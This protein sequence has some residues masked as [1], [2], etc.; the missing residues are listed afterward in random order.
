[1]KKELLLILVPLI[2]IC[3]SSHAYTTGDAIERI[4]GMSVL[5]TESP[6]FLEDWAIKIFPKDTIVFQGRHP[7]HIAA[8]IEI[9]SRTADVNY[10]HR[11]VIFLD[12]NGNLQPEAMQVAR[13][14]GHEGWDGI[15]GYGMDYGGPAWMS[16]DIIKY[17]GKMYPVSTLGHITTIHE[18]E[19]MYG[20]EF[21]YEFTLNKCVRELVDIRY[22]AWNRFGRFI[23]PEE[24]P[25][26][27]SIEGWLFSKSGK[28][29]I[30]AENFYDEKRERGKTNFILRLLNGELSEEWENIDT[31]GEQAFLY[32]E[33]GS[34]KETGKRASI[35][36]DLPKHVKVI[37]EEAFFGSNLLR[38]S[39]TIPET[40]RYVG[41]WAFDTT[42]T[43]RVVRF[44]GTTPPKFGEY[45][46]ESGH[47]FIAEIFNWNASTT[48]IVPDGCKN[49]YKEAF[50]VE[51]INLVEES[52]YAT[53]VI[54]VQNPTIKIRRNANML[55]LKGCKQG[56]QIQI[57]STD[58][59]MISNGTSSGNHDMLFFL[60]WEQK[61]VIVRVGNRQTF[62]IK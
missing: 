30:N 53:S 18:Q 8:H 34:F 22:P 43:F 62:K 14:N 28:T 38:D 60:P 31:I 20:K 49:A 39:L 7:I 61:N 29:L 55:T 36:I 45:E 51:G 17:G 1:M 16:V 40:V 2:V 56:E 21:F 47:K 33:Q 42:D 57:Y 35:Y 15:L 54:S 32:A 23:V 50:P 48:F 19:Q 59:K 3:Q 46:D 11:F 13:G 44:M 5:N 37:G 52:E 41:D 12:K 27:M 6:A 58:G 25:Y 9:L 26:L 10:A 24:N 4:N